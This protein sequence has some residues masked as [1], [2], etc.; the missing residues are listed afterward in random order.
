LI[1]YDI[2][3]IINNNVSNPQFKVEESLGV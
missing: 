2:D 1:N 3:I